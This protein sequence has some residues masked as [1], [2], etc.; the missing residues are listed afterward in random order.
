M[1]EYKTIDGFKPKTVFFWTQPKLK[2][3]DLEK[4]PSSN[5]SHT[6]PFVGIKENPS[7]QDGIIHVC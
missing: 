2:T 1:S 6:E 7:V 3:L 4:E 5:R